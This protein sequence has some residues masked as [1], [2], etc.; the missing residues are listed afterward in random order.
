MASVC[1]LLSSS[2]HSQIMVDPNK[3][4]GLGTSTPS[5]PFQAVG[6]NGNEFVFNKLNDNGPAYLYLI[7]GNVNHLNGF[8]LRDGISNTDDFFIG[9]NGS[10]NKLTIRD[11]VGD[12]TIA[13]FEKGGN[14]GIKHDS[15]TTALDVDGK[16]TMRDGAMPGYI[17]V[18]DASGTMVW[19]DPT[20]MAINGENIYNTDD[21]L[22]EN[23]TL[24][25]GVYDLTF[26]QNNA[27]DYFFFSS[28][29]EFA[30]N[31]FGTDLRMIPN[32]NEGILGTFTDK[33]LKI[34]TNGEDRLYVGDS[35]EDGKIGI[36]TTSPTS[37]LHVKYATY[38]DSPISQGTQA[39]SSSGY[40]IMNNLGTVQW[41]LIS[42]N[43]NNPNAGNFG[44]YNSVLGGRAMTI[45][46]SNDYFGFGTTEPDFKLHSFE[47]DD[48]SWK[49]ES[50]G[51]RSN[52]VIES[53][54]DTDFSRNVFKQGVSTNRW[55]IGLNESANDRF[56]IAHGSDMV[57]PFFQV[58]NT[59]IVH[60]QRPSNLGG[61]III[62]KDDPGIGGA[63]VL[64]E[65]YFE[66]NDGGLSTV[67]ASAV[68]RAITSEPQGPN[69]K[70]AHLTFLTKP[71][72]R[73]G[74]QSAIERMRINHA[75]N[76][77]INTNSPSEKL[78]IDGKIRI[79]TGAINGYVLVCD[80]NG[81]GTW[82]DPSTL[83]FSG[84]TPPTG[85]KINNDDTL[86]ESVQELKN[87]I[88]GLIATI[89]E[90]EKKIEELEKAI[91]ELRE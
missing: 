16:I 58:E 45:D 13:T 4:T 67:D 48:T 51:G 30:S 91:Q 70:G 1:L 47:T 12:I 31:A 10:D 43:S 56:V 64:G 2:L 80:G 84:G 86:N 55:E 24:G 90:Q 71:T 34:K 66:G 37:S 89:V 82:T 26:E 44:I 61:R 88:P 41:S 9:K 53:G 87:L 73:D 28:D 21:D 81:V 17:P 54:S 63:E 77:G 60:I 36:G 74:S 22:T 57:D 27:G 52:I 33:P 62:K 20:A 69:D 50:S 8:F 25:M 6:H 79:R 35:S 29:G 19:T 65:V 68:I 23:R 49:I 40:R 32:T 39:N 59:G 42:S 85:E 46:A 18:S 38:L 78:D 75:G 72:N 76:I 11:V 5:Y 15:P 83:P 7:S 3:N 14:V